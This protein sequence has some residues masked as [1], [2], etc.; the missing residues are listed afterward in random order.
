MNIYRILDGTESVIPSNTYRVFATAYHGG[1][2]S[3]ENKSIRF[4]QDLGSDIGF[5]FSGVS[6]DFYFELLDTTKDPCD[7]A[8]HI[9]SQG[10]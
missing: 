2:G 9:I 5:A 3:I 10:F 6:I 7:V 1:E 4:S 8:R